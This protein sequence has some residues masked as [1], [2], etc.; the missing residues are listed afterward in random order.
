MLEAIIS[1]VSFIMW[2]VVLW[3]LWAYLTESPASKEFRKDQAKKNKTRNKKR[4]T[5]HV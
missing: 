3:I 5:N 2:P 4:K 1:L